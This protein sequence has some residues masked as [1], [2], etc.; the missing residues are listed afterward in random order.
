[1]ATTNLEPLLREA[2]R[3]AVL[4]VLRGHPEWTLGDVFVEPPPCTR[5]DSR[6]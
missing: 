6:P 2:E 5:E 4:A 1:M 3:R